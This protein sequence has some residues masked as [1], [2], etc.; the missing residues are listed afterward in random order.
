MSDGCW[1]PW[2]KSACITVK[3]HSSVASIVFH[4]SGPKGTN[5]TY[6]HSRGQ[7]WVG[8]S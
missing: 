6:N 7:P 4:G 3:V 8:K 1:G 2:P 5:S